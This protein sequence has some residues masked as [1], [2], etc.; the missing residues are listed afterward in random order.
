MLDLDGLA[1]IEGA[2]SDDPFLVFL[3]QDLANDFRAILAADEI[4]GVLAGNDLAGI[5]DRLGDV[6][7]GEASANGGEIRTDTP[8]F[9]AIAVAGGAEGGLEHPFPV[10]LVAAIQSAFRQFDHRIDGPF[11]AGSLDLGQIS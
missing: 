9:V 5:E 10:F 11:A 4:E 1:E 8:S 6:V 3:L 7:H 2:G